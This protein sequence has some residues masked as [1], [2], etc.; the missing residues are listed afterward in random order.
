MKS[1]DSSAHRRKKWLSDT[2]VIFG[3]SNG[4]LNGD[5]AVIYKFYFS[6]TFLFTFNYTV[7]VFPPSIANVLPIPISNTLLMILLLF[8]PLINPINNPRTSK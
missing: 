2:T 6:P 5:D 4:S 1:L 3:Y 7:T 8:Y